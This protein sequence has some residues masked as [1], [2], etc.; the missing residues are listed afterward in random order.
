[1]ANKDN[2]G[3]FLSIAFISTIILGFVLF[4]NLVDGSQNKKS[5]DPA[6]SFTLFAIALVC[7]F[8]YIITKDKKT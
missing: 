6:L 4:G 1:M 2:S 8:I 7:Y 3:C 5:T